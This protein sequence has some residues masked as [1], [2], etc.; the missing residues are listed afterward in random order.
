MSKRWLLIPRLFWFFFLAFV[1]FC[2]LFSFFISLFSVDGVELQKNEQR[3]YTT[4]AHC[5]FLVVVVVFFCST[6]ISLPKLRKNGRW[7]LKVLDL[8]HLLLL[9]LLLR[10][11][12]HHLTC[13]EPYINKMQNKKKKKKGKVEKTPRLFVFLFFYPH[14]PIGLLIAHLSHLNVQNRKIKNQ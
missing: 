10:L 8:N 14:H 4:S 3:I 9:L 6:V 13:N 2:F 12:L 1:L 5:Y 7:N 11:L